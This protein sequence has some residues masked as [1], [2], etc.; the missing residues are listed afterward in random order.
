ME[1]E[2]TVVAALVQT[3]SLV[4]RELPVSEY[5]GNA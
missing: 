2:Q 1:G 4:N 5:L 3:R